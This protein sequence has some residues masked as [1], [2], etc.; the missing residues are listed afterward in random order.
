MTINEIHE[1]LLTELRMNSETVFQDYFQKWKR[2]W[3]K[4]M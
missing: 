4:S 2:G 1:N 3:Q